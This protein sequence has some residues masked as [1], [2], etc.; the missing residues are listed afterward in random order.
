MGNV[1]DHSLVVSRNH[2]DEWRVTDDYCPQHPIQLT[3]LDAVE[4][5][6][7]PVLKS[8]FSAPDSVRSTKD[9]VERDARASQRV[10]Q[11]E[12]LES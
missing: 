1:R 5:F 3:E 10:S 12:G 7:M 6:L 4:A 9:R 11:A 2:S 8:L